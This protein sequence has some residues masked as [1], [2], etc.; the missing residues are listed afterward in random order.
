MP[1]LRNATQLNSSYGQDLIKDPYQQ[2]AVI[3]KKA[4][5]RTD[6]A[7]FDRFIDTLD[8][9]GVDSKKT[10]HA[11]LQ[12]KTSPFA[13]LCSWLSFKLHLGSSAT[14][15]LQA[16]RNLSKQLSMPRVL[17]GVCPH[18]RRI[19]EQAVVCTPVM[20]GMKK[21]IRLET[22][23]VDGHGH[24]SGA[25]TIIPLDTFHQEINAPCGGTSLLTS[26]E[27]QDIDLNAEVIK[28]DAELP[29]LNRL[30]HSQNDV[31]IAFLTSLLMNNA[32]QGNSTP[33][34]N[35]WGLGQL[36][37]MN[38][39]MNAGPDEVSG[40]AQSGLSVSEE[41]KTWIAEVSLSSED[42]VASAAEADDFLVIQ[43]AVNAGCV[44]SEFLI[45][46]LFDK[47]TNLQFVKL[48]GQTLSTRMMMAAVKA[49]REGRAPGDM[50]HGADLSAV[51]FKKIGSLKGIHFDK[52]NIVSVIE[53]SN[54]TK[55]EASS[56]IRQAIEDKRAPPDALTQKYLSETDFHGLAGISRD[57]TR[58]LHIRHI[59]ELAEIVNAPTLITLDADM[60]GVDFRNLD[61]IE[62]LNFAGAD[63]RGSVHDTK[64]A[65]FF[66]DQVRRQRVAPDIL[67]STYCQGVD[68]SHQDISQM[69]FT[70]SVLD[71]GIFV[72]TRM[73]STRFDG[74]SLHDTRF[75][76]ATPD[77]ACLQSLIAA[78]ENGKM[79]SGAPL[80]ELDRT[81]I[82]F[83]DDISLPQ[84]AVVDYYQRVRED[85][86]Q[87]N[88][89]INM[90]PQQLDGLRE[91]AAE[92]ERS[93][94]SLEKHHGSLLKRHREVERYFRENNDSESFN[95]A[96]LL[97]AEIAGITEKIHSLSTEY[98]LVTDQI[99]A[100]MKLPKLA[101]CYLGGD[102]QHQVQRQTDYFTINVDLGL[103]IDPIRQWSEPL[104]QLSAP[105]Q[106]SYIAMAIKENAFQ[107]KVLKDVN[108]SGWD[109]SG[110]YL[111]KT[112]FIGVDAT[113]ANFA[114]AKIFETVFDSTNL[115]QASMNNSY[116]DDVIFNQCNLKYT[117]FSDTIFSGDRCV[118]HDV[119]IND[120]HFEQTTFTREVIAGIV[121][122]FTD[123]NPESC[124][125]LHNCDFSGLRLDALDLRRI[126]LTGDRT[127]LDGV[128]LKDARLSRQMIHSVFEI[129]RQPGSGLLFGDKSVGIFRGSDWHDVDIRGLELMWDNT[130]YVSDEM[131]EETATGLE[132]WEDEFLYSN[133]MGASLSGDID[134][135]S[136]N[137]TS[138]PGPGRAVRK[139]MPD[140]RDVN[141]SGVRMDRNNVV[142]LVTAAETGLA[143]VSVF[144][145]ANLNNT[146][147]SHLD[148]RPFDFSKTLFHDARFTYT[149]LNAGNEEQFLMGA[150]EGRGDMPQGY[151]IE[152]RQSADI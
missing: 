144:S 2:Y 105:N 93:Q 12:T 66:V 116:I 103:K 53:A 78:Y 79:A 135:T 146:D 26:L 57:A 51:N 83:A 10:L 142:A 123:P 97:A 86:D 20:A 114:H 67:A 152:L 49:I 31:D 120:A 19:G 43:E 132:G 136:E 77:D 33:E 28:A 124:L 4:H 149:T 58:S 92:L 7:S 13:K 147:L 38:I 81:N 106:A 40:A 62:V 87:L 151:I 75:P 107:H 85:L 36:L 24:L 1:E 84:G 140:L 96:N 22:G 138:L 27:T 113:G 55:E 100:S 119:R 56:L 35:S 109:F 125:T 17:D 127:D 60:R 9:C 25:A 61:G 69:K 29:I 112:K 47:S 39:L 65:A 89:I 88:T 63:I 145:E 129:V 122:A 99:N 42:A 74:A 90:T 139:S 126:R 117:D 3:L 110:F 118:M 137:N 71:G 121:T 150:L 98:K 64:S 18:I 108:V 21:M 131:G 134:L 14:R 32:Y 72:N 46:T 95:D 52:G 80:M 82:R 45:E 104:S 148:L 5:I 11:L 48:T 8:R 15:D 44:N 130:S 34:Q 50:L 59:I 111:S 41:I 91:K 73:S 30:L 133:K 115:S 68:W 54:K 94:H 6:S 141:F 23:R 128:S 102:A 76:G 70:D 16:L 37:Q 143:N 101:Y